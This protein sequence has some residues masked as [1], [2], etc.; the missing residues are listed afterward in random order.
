MA[1]LM[2]SSRASRLAESARHSYR[3]VKIVDDGKIVNAT[4]IYADNDK[5]AIELAELFVDGY[6]IELWDGPRFIEHFPSVE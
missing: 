1:D 6:A 3:A 5:Q 4:R 2:S